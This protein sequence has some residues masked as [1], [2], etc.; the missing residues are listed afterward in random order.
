M[1]SPKQAPSDDGM[2][3]RLVVIQRNPKSGSG[4]RREKILEL[5]AALKVHGFRPHLFF[6]PRAT[7]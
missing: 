6:K 1:A 5:I 2:N 4:P 3:D 7:C